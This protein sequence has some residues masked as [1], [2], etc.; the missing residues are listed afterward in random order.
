MHFHLLMQR[1]YMKGSGG[2]N[3]DKR[4]FI[5]TRSAYAGIQRYSAANWSGDIAARWHDMEAQIPGGLNL[6]MSGIPWWTMDIG[7]FAVESRYYNPSPEDLEE[8][9]ELMTRWYQYGAFCPI[10]RSHGQYPYREIFNI[11]PASHPAYQSMLSYDR[12]RYRLMPYIYS[13]AGHAWLNDYTI[14]RGLAMD[15]T[16]D[17]KVHDIKDQYMFGPALLVN[18]VYEYKA[19]SRKVYLPASCGWYDFYTGRYLRGGQLVD[20]PA[21]YERIPLYIKEGS[22]IPFGPE[23]QYSTEKPAEP[24]SLFVYTGADGRFVLYEDENNNYNYEEGAYSLISFNYNEQ[25]KTLTIGRRQGE[26]PGMLRG[27]TF[28]IFTVTEG[29]Q[30]A[31]DP[32]QE[33][34]ITVKYDGSPQRIK[35]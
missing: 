32:D 35:L 1:L 4:V 3:P 30:Q 15:F 31:T 5:L 8:W 28:R 7:G 6:S 26:Y 23:L 17:S 25:D 9:R 20:A 19:R 2:Q 11:A 34:Y 22:I 33:T 14:M 24:I 27:R 13:L 10:F 29:K 21:P 18:P 12:L 16:A